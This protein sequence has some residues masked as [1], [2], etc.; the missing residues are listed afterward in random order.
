MFLK[1]VKISKELAKFTG[2][3]PAVEKSRVDVTK[4]ICNYIKDNNLQN[5]T[6]RRQIQVEKDPKFKKLL[7]FDS[8]SGVLTYYSLQTYLK[9]HF[10]SNKQISK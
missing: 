5:P 9:K 1:P 7:E 2:W 4:Y 10:V 6:D 3:D 8:G